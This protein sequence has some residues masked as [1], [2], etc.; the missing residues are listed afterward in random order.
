[1]LDPRHR[2]HFGELLRLTTEEVA[3]VL[4]HV[5]F[6]TLEEVVDEIVSLRCISQ[7]LLVGLLKLN[8]ALGF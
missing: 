3:A 7:G 6:V 1:M 8:L 5:F 4:D 2:A